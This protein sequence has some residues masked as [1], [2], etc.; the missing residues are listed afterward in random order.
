MGRI[1]VIGG[2]GAFGARVSER[3]AREPSLDV[4]IAGRREDAAR[5]AARELSRSAQARVSHAAFNAATATSDGLSAFGAGVVINASGPFQAQSYDLARACIAARCH[6]V[7]LADARAFANGI[8]VLDGDARAAGV[9]VIS[10]ASSVPGLSTAVVRQFAGAFQDLEA[11]EIGIS[12]GNSFDPG[13]ATTASILGA[14]GAPHNVLE[15]GRR[16][17]AYGWQGL[18]RHRFPEIG[19]RLMSR[20]D[21]PDLDLL[22]EHFPSLKSVRFSA[23]AE[24][25][26]Y[27]LALWSLSWLRRAGLIGDPGRL[28]S[29]LLGAK[30]RLRFLGSDRGGM[31]VTLRGRDAKGKLHSVEWVLVARS[32]DGPYVPAMASVILAK[33]LAAATGPPPGAQ[34]CFALFTLADFEAE[35][36]DL[37]ISFH[38]Q[39][40]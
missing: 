17:T 4:I 31:F 3:L 9:S 27:H 40:C 29:P 1:L 7:D 16:Q 8:T 14:V 34:P 6:Y 15:D 25:G 33:R 22:P 38:T 24:V 28:A 39:S 21:V 36:A 35:V 19:T 20:V 11:I 10:G 23:G 5:N 30:R 26:P 12:P 2:Y 37:D 18:R 32:G 13:L